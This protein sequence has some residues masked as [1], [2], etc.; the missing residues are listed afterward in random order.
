MSWHA[1]QEPECVNKRGS[2]E[3][4]IKPRPRDLG[5]VQLAR[6]L[7]TWQRQMVGPFIFLDRAGPA[8]FGRG[9]G[10]D[11][12]PHPH[13]SPA[14]ERYTDDAADRLGSRGARLA[15]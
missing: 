4:V 14:T 1:Y 3:R 10:A 15:T 6:V 12:R 2:I 7:P 9:R 8:Q 5:G 11:V 13:I